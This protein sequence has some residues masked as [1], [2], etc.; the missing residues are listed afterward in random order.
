MEARKIY[1]EVFRKDPEFRS[2]YVDNV[3]VILMARIGGDM[4][5][6][7]KRDPIADEIIERIFGEP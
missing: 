6:K 1:A 3:S 4:L 7:S 5:D 2:T